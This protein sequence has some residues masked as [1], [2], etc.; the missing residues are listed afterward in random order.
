MKATA[1]GFVSLLLLATSAEAERFRIDIIGISVDGP[2]G[3]VV[4][5][6]QAVRENL[7]ALKFGS[8]EFKALALQKITD[9]LLQLHQHPEPWPEL[10]PSFSIKSRPGSVSDPRALLIALSPT[11]KGLHEDTEFVQEPIAVEIAGRGAATMSMRYTLRV[12]GS[13]T[14]FPTYSRIWIVPD[15]TYFVMIGAGMPYPPPPDIEAAID[16]AIESVR[17]D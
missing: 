4:A 2:P 1:I 8:P 10:N 5:T 11:M 12:E 16:A 7:E 15:E 13:D 14:A 17:F 3:W 6:P 9:P